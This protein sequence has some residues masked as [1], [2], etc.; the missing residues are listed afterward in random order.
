[1]D[2]V[3]K[4]ARMLES[5]PAKES[6]LEDCH[7]WASSEWCK[8]P[9]PDFV[10]LPVMRLAREGVSGGFIRKDELAGIDIF[11]QPVTRPDMQDEHGMTFWSGTAWA[12]NATEEIVK[13]VWF[14]REK[15]SDDLASQLATALRDIS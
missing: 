12:K 13:Q 11:F 8:S 14:C 9:A 7:K 6:E 15:A 2:L 4:I 5:M 1:M 3:T 10:R